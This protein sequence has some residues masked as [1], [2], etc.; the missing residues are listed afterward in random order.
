[1]SKSDYWRTAEAVA[2]DLRLEAVRTIARRRIVM[3]IR[4]T[5]LAMILLLGLLSQSLPAAESKETKRVLILYSE[6][7]DHPAHELTDRGIRET[8]ESSEGFGLLLYTEVFEFIPLC[9]REA[10][11]QCCR[12]LGREVF[13]FEDRRHHRVYP[14]PL[15]LLLK[16]ARKAFPGVPI[17][18]CSLL[19]FQVNLSLTVRL[20]NFITFLK[21]HKKI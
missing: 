5:I 13:P 12:V 10:S 19:R 14:A 2:T 16:E 8:F 6:D 11:A 3:K 17:V 15:N 21:S 20:L 18:G 7:T 1:M 9:H 4:N